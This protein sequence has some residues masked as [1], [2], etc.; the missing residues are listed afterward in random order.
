M[1]RLTLLL[2]LFGVLNLGLF[3]FYPGNAAAVDVIGPG[4]QTAPGSAVCQ[5]DQTASGDTNN[6]LFGP[7]GVIT[8]VVQILVVIVGIIAVITMML[9]GLKIITSGGN[10]DAAASGRRG[11][12]YSLIGLLMAFMAQAIVSFVLSKL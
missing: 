11:V 4:C 7:S 6:P 3:S 5:D 1:K 12:I 8:K 2:S 10:A 9:S